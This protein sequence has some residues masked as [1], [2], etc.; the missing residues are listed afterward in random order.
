M[1]APCAVPSLPTC[2]SLPAFCPSASWEE[3][4]VGPSGSKQQSQGRLAP[5]CCGRMRGPRLAPALPAPAGAARQQPV[6]RAFASQGLA[7]CCGEPRGC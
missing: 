5:G 1:S 2:L 6:R 3:G 7:G 4:A